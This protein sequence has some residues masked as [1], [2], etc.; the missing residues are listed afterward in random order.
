MDQFGLLLELLQK[1]PQIVIGAVLVF[2][3]LRFREYDK[4]LRECN[5]SPKKTIV[6]KLNE[7]AVDVRHLTA[8]QEQMSKQ[9]NIL[10]G[11]QIE[12]DRDRN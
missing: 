3:A 1:S 6:E 9:V 4:H 10:V 2:G 5:E 7:L 11:R 8:N 12:R